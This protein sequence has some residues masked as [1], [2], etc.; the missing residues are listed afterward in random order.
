MR[1]IYRQ[2]RRNAGGAAAIELVAVLG[3]ILIPL[4]VA[5]LFFGRFVWHYSVAQK[6]AQDAARFVAASSPTEMKTQCTLLIYKDPCVVMAAMSL[7]T[8]EMAELN[9]GGKDTPSVAVYCDEQKCA[10]NKDTPVPRMI[11]VDIK[12]TVEDP[13]FTVFTS[14]FSGT[15][16][17]IS[18]PIHATGRSYY[19]GN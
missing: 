12:M 15:A 6:A 8:T 17:P 10:T 5:S 16:G 2:P 13:F 7:A 1:R 9:P 11:S 3:V 19:V 14:A 18:I 4:L